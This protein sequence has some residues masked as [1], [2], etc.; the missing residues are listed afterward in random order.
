MSMNIS[1]RK[2]AENI[3]VSLKCVTIYESGPCIFFLAAHFFLQRGSHVNNGFY[4]GPS[5]DVLRGSL[6]GA[7]KLITIK[8]TSASG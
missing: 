1:L 2:V 4:I 6:R 5:P 3:R 8:K 7:A